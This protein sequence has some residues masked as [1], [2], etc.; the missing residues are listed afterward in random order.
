MIEME[1]ILADHVLV[2]GRNAAACNAEDC[3]WEVR[4]PPEDRDRRDNDS[5]IAEFARHQAD[6]LRAAGFE[7]S[8]NARQAKFDRVEVRWPRDGY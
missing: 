8:T 7:M 5:I 3:D 1:R 6:L 2:I 4:V